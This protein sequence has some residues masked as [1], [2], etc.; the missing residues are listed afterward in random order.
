MNEEI[1]YKKM[2]E[3]TDTIIKVIIDNLL[4]GTQKFLTDLNPP[5]LEVNQI[6]ASFIMSCVMSLLSTTAKYIKDNYVT[7]GC[8]NDFIDQV[9]KEFIDSMNKIKNEDNNIH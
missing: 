8:E 7:D 3:H 1:I 9:T 6:K 2:L 4:E 5:H